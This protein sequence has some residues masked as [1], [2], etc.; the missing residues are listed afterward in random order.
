MMASSCLFAVLIWDSELTRLEGVMLLGLLIA[1]VAL[2]IRLARQG[3]DPA[4]A[5]EI[6]HHLPTAKGPV[7]IDLLWMA[8][9]I[10]L[11]VSGSS[12]LVTGAV[13]VATAAGVSEAVIG[14]TLIA[15]GT[16]LPELATTVVAAA[17]KETDLAVGNVVGSNIFNVLC[18]G[19]AA[20]VVKPIRA[21]DIEGIDLGA[22][23]A[24]SLLVLPLC[25]SG[26]RV[27]RR[28]GLLLLA[29]YG[30]YLYAIWPKPH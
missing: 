30:A 27:R 4:L 25:W 23:I 19:G 5:E 11:L 8:G 22:M 24:V 2:T 13:S 9:G 3:K 26:L 14:L 7:F 28:E 18:I 20:A 15:A 21:Q 29:C 17:K 12:L 6:A 1:Y 16:G 10:G